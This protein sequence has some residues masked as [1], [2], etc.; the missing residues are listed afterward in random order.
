MELEDL[1]LY[2]D[3]ELNDD[4]EEIEE[5]QRGVDQLF[6]NELEEIA[7]DERFYEGFPSVNSV[8]LENIVE[9][10]IPKHYSEEQKKFYDQ[11]IKEIKKINKKYNCNLN[12]NDIVDS[13]NAGYKKYSKDLPNHL[14]LA[15]CMASELWTLTGYLAVEMERNKAYSKMPL[16]RI[17]ND[18]KRNFKEISKIVRLYTK[19]EPEK[20]PLDGRRS[21]YVFT[22]KGKVRG[23]F[24]I[25]DHTSEFHYEY[26]AQTLRNNGMKTSKEF[27]LGFSS[28]EA[29]K[30]ALV[31]RVTKIINKNGAIANTQGERVVKLAECV[32]L[33]RPLQA[34]RENR[35]ILEFFT[36][37]K[38]YVAERDALRQCKA[39]MK[40]LGLSSE[41]IS[42][43]LHGGA[44]ND[45]VFNDGLTARE[46]QANP[47]V[48]DTLSQ[49][50]SGR[51]VN[52]HK[53]EEHNSKRIGIIVDEV[54]TE[55]PILENKIEEEIK[56][57]NKE[58]TLV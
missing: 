45:V 55:M 14:T 34:K 41:E 4:E 51:L 42:K 17:E 22:A 10:N 35:S 31:N 7:E 58:T 18:L 20:V 30:D 16:K 49:P 13:L 46:K 53:I 39:E 9:D 50:E 36:N 1:E 37:H 28:P 26:N 52:V 8:L 15:D 25:K 43:V 32:R 24:Q 5:D 56:V 33:L 48:T 57:Q 29:V 40:Q 12:F 38:V 11:G 19:I 6:D 27:F 54:I 47:T 44:F 23:T 3:E 2:D 21:N